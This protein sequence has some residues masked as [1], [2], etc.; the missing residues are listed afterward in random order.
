MEEYTNSKEWLE[1][2]DSWVATMNKSK[3][4]KEKYREYLKKH[5]LNA[6]DLP[7]VDWLRNEKAK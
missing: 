1:I 6:K 4:A 2:S 5:N 3:E 7:Y